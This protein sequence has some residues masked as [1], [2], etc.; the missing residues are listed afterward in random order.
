MKIIE[1][2]IKYIG[3]NHYVFGTFGVVNIHESLCG[4]GM[5]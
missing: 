5:R 4:A 2:H 1:N 3:K